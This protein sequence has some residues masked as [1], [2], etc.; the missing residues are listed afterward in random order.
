[1]SAELRSE[2]S[3]GGNTF[4]ISQAGSEKKVPW[5]MSLTGKF[6]RDLA[7]KCDLE[8]PNNPDRHQ[9]TLLLIHALF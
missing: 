7:V 1:M 4:S 3:L 5:K 8:K 6:V 2:S 9:D